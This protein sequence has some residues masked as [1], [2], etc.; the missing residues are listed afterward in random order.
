MGISK[1]HNNSIRELFCA[2][3]IAGH[4]DYEAWRKNFLFSRQRLA[5]ILALVATCSFIA[6]NLI[7]YPAIDWM[8]MQLNIMQCIAILLFAGLLYSPFGRAHPGVLLV[9]F[10]SILTLLPQFQGALHGFMRFDIIT[11]TLV[12]LGQATLMPVHWRLHM[13]SQIIALTTH[14]TLSMSGGL[15]VVDSSIVVT[16]TLFV[17]FYQLWFCIICNFSVYLYERLQRAEFKSRNQLKAEREKTEKLLL[18]ILPYPIAERLRLTS[19]TIADDFTE[20]SVLF[21]D[22]VGFTRMSSQLE[23][24]HLVGMLNDIFSRFDKL[25]EQHALEKIKTIGDAYMV[26]AGLPEPVSDH[27]GRIAALALDMRQAITEFNT[28]HGRQVNIRIGIHCGPVVA[29]VIGIK[30]FAYDL[31]GDTVNVASRME[32]HGVPGEI[33]ISGDMYRA[34]KDKYHCRQRGSINIKGKG[35]MQVYFLENRKEA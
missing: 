4:A 34:I 14:A 32:S 12:F 10:S 16:D 29:G 8:L 33:Q 23:P 25:V 18:N 27:A 22:L 2:P 1:E 31:W 7:R 20:V 21:A 13:L 5:I 17:Y 19:D 28:E 11:W 35:E 15:E 24:S 26:V 30:K 6:F 3:S 9:L